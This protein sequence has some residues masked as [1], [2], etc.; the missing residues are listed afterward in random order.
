MRMAIITCLKSTPAEIEIR[1]EYYSED[2]QTG[3]QII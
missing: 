2:V 1:E 3:E